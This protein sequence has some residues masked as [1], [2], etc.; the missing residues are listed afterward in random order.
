[1]LKDCMPV[2]AR[3]DDPIWTTSVM[4]REL[5]RVIEGLM[6]AHHKHS[7]GDEKGARIREADAR[8]NFADLITQCRVLAEQLNWPW[9]T[10][11]KDGEERFQ[12]RMQ[13]ITE[14]RL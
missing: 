13:E 6:Y 11:L 8:I 5:G 7:W 2:Q 3:P 10:L 12:E 4:S 9:L 1:M 14:K